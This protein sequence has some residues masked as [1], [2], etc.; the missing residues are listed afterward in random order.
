M[1]CTQVAAALLEDSSL[2]LIKKLFL[3]R[4]AKDTLLLAS[5]PFYLAVVVKMLPWI[6]GLIKATLSGDRVEKAGKWL[7]G[8]KKM[9]AS[10]LTVCRTIL[11]L[12]DEILRWFGSTLR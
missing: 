7:C 8:D 12:T 9:T 5:L 2:P 3:L 1:E 4:F 11:Q 10:D 6:T